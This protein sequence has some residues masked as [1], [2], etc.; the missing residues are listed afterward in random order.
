MIRS[1]HFR[2]NKLT[3]TLQFDEHQILGL[4]DWDFHRVVPAS[5]HTV[6]A[7]QV[8]WRLTLLTVSACFQLVLVYSN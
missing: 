1:R 5:S 4:E 6:R 8:Q 7:Y 2:C 3:D